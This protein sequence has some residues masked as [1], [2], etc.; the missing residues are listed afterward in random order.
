MFAFCFVR[1]N[2]KGKVQPL[3]LVHFGIAIAL[4][5]QLV[6]VWKQL[7]AHDICCNLHTIKKYFYYNTLLLCENRILLKNKFSLGRLPN[8]GSSLCAFFIKHGWL[9]VRCAKKSCYVMGPCFRDRRSDFKAVSY[10]AAVRRIHCKR[11]TGPNKAA[12]QIS[13]WDVF[14]G[15]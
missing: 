3:L 11:P 10:S 12:W 4:L 1:T 7:D 9:L 5:N 14:Y 6:F 15:P 2:H 8:T 13:K